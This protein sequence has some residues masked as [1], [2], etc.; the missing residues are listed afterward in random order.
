[1]RAERR[2]GPAALAAVG[3]LLACAP[4]ASANGD[5]SLYE[6]GVNPSGTPG[7]A[8]VGK[9]SVRVP[10]TLMPCAGGHGQ[11]GLGR[12]EGG[13]TPPAITWDNLTKPY[14][15]RHADG[16]SHP[17]FTRESLRRAIGEGID[18]AGNRSTRR[19]RVTRW[20]PPTSTS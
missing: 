20:R 11:D 1:M 14:G 10:A 7:F 3:L 13:I 6:D 16:R 12:P 18:P 15:H 5:R 19:C 2:A 4:P 8:R 17:P 9:S